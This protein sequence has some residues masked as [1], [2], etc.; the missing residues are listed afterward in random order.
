[1]NRTWLRKPVFVLSLLLFFPHPGKSQRADHGF[2]TSFQIEK[3][4]SKRWAISFEQ[5][6]KLKENFSQADEFYTEI[7]GCYKVLP[8]LKVSLG[9]RFI[10]KVD[11]QKYYVDYLRFGHRF[12]GEAQYKYH[13]HLVT[14]ILKTRIE[15]ELKNVYSSDKGKIP[16]WDWK[17]KIEVK[18]RLMRLEPYVGAE[19][20]YQF[21][22]PRH[23]ES[24]FLLNRIWV[25]AGIDYSLMRNHTIG[26]Y[27]LYQK[28]WNLTD[29]ENRFVIGLNYAISL[30]SGRKKAGK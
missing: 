27:Y 26:I 10:E 16:A 11:L 30:P 25:Y 18:Y 13:I 6:I 4:I 23:P 8:G 24:N 20:R 28:E 3:A 19:L 15:S 5:D 14:L 12:L 29:A 17:N 22:D 7:D 21:T 9:Y 2:W 1:M